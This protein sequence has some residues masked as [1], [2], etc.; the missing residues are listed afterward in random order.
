[1]R[2][3]EALNHY[4]FHPFPMVHSKASH[5]AQS[6]V[7]RLSQPSTPGVVLRG[8]SPPRATCATCGRPWSQ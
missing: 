7:G 3:Y 1:M 4:P 8:V 2:H 5:A 6:G